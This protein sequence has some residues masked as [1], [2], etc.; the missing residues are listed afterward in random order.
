MSNQSKNVISWRNRTKER[1]IQ[2][3]GGSCGICGYKK[4]QRSLDLHHLDPNE[5]DFSL[6]AIRARP[7]S[8]ESIVQELRKCV[9]LC[10][11]CHGE[12]HDGMTDL[13]DT[14]LRF[15]ESFA[16]YKKILEEDRKKK[17]NDL[18]PICGKEKFYKQKTCSYV[19]SAKISGKYDWDKFDL[20]KLYIDDKLSMLRIAKL[21][22]CSDVAVKKRLV[23]L[24][25][26]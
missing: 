16:D 5:K 13:P 22:G 18:C 17:Y 1:I 20:K 19:C 7:K 23:K 6:S 10:K 9:L 25:L 14:I 4:C 2:S 12:I 24:K 3:F 26:I 11:N 8:W 21:I 15:D